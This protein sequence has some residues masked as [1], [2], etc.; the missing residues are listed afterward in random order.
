MRCREKKKICTA[1]DSRRCRT[2]TWWEEQ[3]SIKNEVNDMKFLCPGFYDETNWIE[4]T[5]GL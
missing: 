1:V 2:T 4:L 3:F 5:V